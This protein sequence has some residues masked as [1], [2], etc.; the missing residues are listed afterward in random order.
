MRFA[1]HSIAA[2]ARRALAAVMLAA[3]CSASL[4][5]LPSHAWLAAAVSRLGG[6]ASGESQAFPC[7]GGSC[8]CAS[9]GECWSACCC[10]TPH[11][12]LVW[13][14]ER[15]V[16]PPT[17]AR[18]SDSEWIAA[19]NAVK[20]GSAHCG[21]CVVGIKASLRKGIA[22]AGAA[23]GRQPKA[24]SCCEARKSPVSASAV[25]SER[26]EVASCC[27]GGDGAAAGC[28]DRPPA[29]PDPARRGL[30]CLSAL[31]CK[32]AAALM[33]V[34]VPPSRPAPTEVTIVTVHLPAPPSCV[35][36]PAAPRPWTMALDVPAPP[37]KRGC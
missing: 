11:E 32:G 30:P 27:G 31:G 26:G 19:A 21:S 8:G 3:F 2:P 6:A 12:R 20:P 4:G 5:V 7:E 1:L 24:K 37:P 29:T 14:L 25:A 22:L 36:S 18:F 23:P 35:A 15:G 10:N 28:C 17:A 34:P 33:T 9:S 16:L 13:A